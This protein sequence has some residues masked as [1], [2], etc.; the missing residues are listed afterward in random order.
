MLREKKRLFIEGKLNDANGDSRQTWKILKQLMKK[1]QTTDIPSVVIDG[2]METDAEK[3]C[4]GLNKYF[5]ESVEQINSSINSPTQT[6]TINNDNLTFEFKSVSRKSIEQYLMGLKNKR[7]VDFINPKTIIDSLSVTGL[8]L[9]QI[10]N[11]SLGDGDVS[12]SLKVSTVVSVYRRK[13]DRNLLKTTDQL[14]RCV[15]WKN[16]WK[17]L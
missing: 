14:I 2:V 5:I 11:E 3:I 10:I 15:L 9:E 13:R 12:E 8:L 6:S 7:D 16:Y 4:E 17:P 1:N